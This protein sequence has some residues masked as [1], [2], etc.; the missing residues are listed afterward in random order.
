MKKLDPNW[1]INGLVDYE[2]KK[3]LLMAYLQ[4]VRSSFSRTEL[5]PFLADLVFHYRNLLSIQKNQSLI[6]ESFP[7]ELT[8]ADFIKL[9]LNYRR[10]IEDDEVMKEIEQI[11]SF[12]VPTIKSALEE[13]K[14]IYEF[15]ESQCEISPVGVTPL[16]ADE[17]YMLVTQA[18]GKETVVYRYQVTVF[19]NVDEKFRGLNTTIIEKSLKSQFYTFESLKIDLVKRYKEL[20][21]PATY[22][23]ISNLKLPLEPTFLPIA[24]RLLMKYISTR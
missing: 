3:Y 23:I 8:S 10:I 4:E 6:K 12:A 21:N 2:Y 13:G 20:P 18:P 16:Y 24:K 22:A 15:I 17:G 9:K 1:L 11:L 5:Y 14:D 19:E 7:K